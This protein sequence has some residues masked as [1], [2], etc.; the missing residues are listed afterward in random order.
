LLLILGVVWEN[1]GNIGYGL[2]LLV[3][4]LWWAKIF[5]DAEACPCGPIEDMLFVGT[6]NDVIQKLAGQLLGA[7]A[8]AK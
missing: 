4:C 7:Y 6:S 1:H 3:L 8:T 5:E 2:A